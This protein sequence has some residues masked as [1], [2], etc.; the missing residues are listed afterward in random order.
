MSRHADHSRRP[1]NSVL[2]LP[3]H[4]RT[5]AAATAAVGTVAIALGALAWTTPVTT[6]THTAT[7]SSQ[8]MT[9]SYTATVARTAAY[10]TTSVHSPDPVFRRL[11][12]TVELHL[13]YRGNPGSI[14]VSAELSTPGG[15]HSSVPLAQPTRFLGNAYDAAVRLDLK[16][17]DGR[18]Q[19]AAA[20]TG[21]PSGP[22]SIAVL[23]R[24]S[25]PGQLPQTPA[26][27]LTL[28][29]LQL[30]LTGAA[31]NLIV[32]IPTTAART[33]EVPRTLGLLG[34]HL[35]V[36]QARRASAILLLLALLA[37]GVL[38][39][40]ARSTAPSTEGA[41]IRRRYAPL[42]AAVQ[43][44]TAPP[45]LPLIEVTEFATLA[46]L[47]E[48]CGLLVLHWSRSHVDTF[49]VLDEGT[50]YRYRAGDK[51]ADTAATIALPPLRVGDPT[52]AAVEE[53]RSQRLP[54]DCQ[55]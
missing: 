12:D 41:K 6:L 22:V 27:N 46:K 29:P 24:I 23:P 1:R 10:D 51:N 17:I 9:F 52:A 11:A 55:H 43:P 50:T 54:R 7:Q 34:R 42:L 26:L 31:T 20:V 45:H 4:L 32:Q 35:T 16:A 47:A 33:T 3:G 8:R 25:T 30:S 38:A 14:S 48:R 39:L 28:T 15:W 36:S 49:I 21:L 40:I 5:S 13:A 44:V 53:P 2:A 19:A 18:A 37:A